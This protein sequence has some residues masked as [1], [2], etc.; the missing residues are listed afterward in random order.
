MATC[1]KTC[2]PKTFASATSKGWLGGSKDASIWNTGVCTT[3]IMAG[4]VPQLED[5]TS[6]M[7]SDG[8]VHAEEDG[9]FFVTGDVV[10]VETADDPQ[11]R[12]EDRAV[13]GEVPAHEPLQQDV[14]RRR[15][16]QKTAPP[17]VEGGVLMP[18]GVRHPIDGLD[19]STEVMERWEEYHQNITEYIQ[20]EMQK[21]DV[22]S[23]E[24]GAY[25][26][27]ALAQMSTERFQVE[28]QMRE[29]R[30]QENEEAQQAEEF[31]TTRTVPAVE[32]YGELELWRESIEK[33]YNQLVKET[34]A[35]FQMT[36]RQ[37]LDLAETRGETIETLP[38]KMVFTR[39]AHSGLRRSRAVCCGNF[40]QDDPDQAVYASGCDAVTTRMTLRMAALKQWSVA[41]VDIKT[42]FL[43]APIKKR[44]WKA[45][46]V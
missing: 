40:A 42:A 4:D 35:V 39:K 7:Q 46:N 11:E 29:M 5:G 43:Q 34:K 2:G 23:E 44:G 8:H 16:H 1:G 45:D 24:G 30:A 3:E 15:L 27:K 33:E 41:G 9:K 32:V 22:T 25:T 20:E 21:A 14:P 19:Q 37:L 36:R 18:V 13:L 12:L 10:Y 38:A 6:A 31:L 26:M 28:E 17:R